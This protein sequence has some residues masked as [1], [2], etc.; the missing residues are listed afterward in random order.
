MT[1][2]AALPSLD[3]RLMSAVGYVRG[4]IVADVG[5]DH[6][7]LPVYLV[8][9]GRA[10]SAVASDINRGP[11]ENAKETVRKYGLEDKITTLIAD[12]LDGI[13]PYHPNDV[14]I[15]G[16]GGELIATIVD[17]AKWTREGTRLILQ[18]MTKPE[19]LRDYLGEVGFRIVDETLSEADGRVYQTLCA[20][21]DGEKREY[22]GLARL[23]GEKNTE[24]GGELFEK[25]AKRLRSTYETRRR[26]K[27][28][29]N[30]N[31][32]EEDAVLAELAKLGIK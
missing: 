4:G 23:L 30:A 16:M 29:S 14:I 18:P 13:E 32:S 22:H 17:R 5:T 6:A 3:G 26:G 25:L 20:E 1:D 19:A 28:M 11:I 10:D 2:K 31:T 9:T 21:Y 15:F 27:A 8:A 7:Y 24:R 12:G